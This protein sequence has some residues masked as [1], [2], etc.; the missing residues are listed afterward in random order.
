MV[1]VDEDSYSYVSE[2]KEVHGAHDKGPGVPVYVMMPSV[3]HHI[4]KPRLCLKCIL[5]KNCVH[6]NQ[7]V[8]TFVAYGDANVIVVMFR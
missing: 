8:I 5:L 1:M 6:C 7:S 2:Y 3:V 4:L